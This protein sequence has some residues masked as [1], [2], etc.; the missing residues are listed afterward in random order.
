[1]GLQTLISSCEH[2]LN[3]DSLTHVM[4]VIVRKG[5]VGEEP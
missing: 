4:T 5:G 3:L 2:G 1:M